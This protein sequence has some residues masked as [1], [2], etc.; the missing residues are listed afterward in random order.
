MCGARLSPPR[1]R[2]LLLKKRIRRLPVVDEAGRLVGIISRSNI[3]RIALEQRKAALDQ[4]A[5]AAA[6]A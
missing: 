2:S 4:P 3:I 6:T 1:P 5:T